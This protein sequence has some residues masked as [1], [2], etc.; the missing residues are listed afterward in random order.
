MSLPPKG[1]DVSKEKHLHAVWKQTKVK[2]PELIG[3]EE[4]EELM[5]L[6]DYYCEARG[7][8][9]LTYAEIESWSRL[10]FKK[11]NSTE[12]DA[13]KRIDA[14]FWEIIHERNSKS[15]NQGKQQRRPGRK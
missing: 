4:P 3:P 8:S 13:L 14:L 12:V 9:R 2:P 5:Y 10:T 6:W 11:V 15:S 7:D 1:S